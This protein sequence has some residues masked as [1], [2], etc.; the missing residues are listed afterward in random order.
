MQG[1]GT[2]SF[3]VARTAFTGKFH[4]AVVRACRRT[5]VANGNNPRIFCQ[6]STHMLFDAMR[7]LGEINRQFHIDIVKI[8]SAHGYSLSKITLEVVGK[9]TFFGIPVFFS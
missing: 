1:Q 5:I 3:G 8:R 9:N 6:Y 2:T 4:I 7:S